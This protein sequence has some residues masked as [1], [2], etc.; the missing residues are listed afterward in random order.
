MATTMM[1]KES[2]S[3]DQPATP[4]QLIYK[5]SGPE[6]KIPEFGMPSAETKEANMARMK[7]V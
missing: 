5:P 4:A 2:Q 6:Y 3:S 1:M 7:K